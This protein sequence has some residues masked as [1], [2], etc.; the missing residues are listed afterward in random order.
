MNSTFEF[1]LKE[2]LKVKMEKFLGTKSWRKILERL[3]RKVELFIGTKTYLT[4][5][6]I[7]YIKTWGNVW[8]TE[9]DHTLMITWTKT[10]VINSQSMPKWQ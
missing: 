5:I 6:F 4:Q 3:K 7:C 10:V 9:T 8:L 1:T 2:G